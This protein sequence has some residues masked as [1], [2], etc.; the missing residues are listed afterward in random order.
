MNLMILNI[1][2]KAKYLTIFEHKFWIIHKY[3]QKYMQ[4]IHLHMHE[5]HLKIGAKK[6]ADFQIGSGGWQ[7][8]I[9]RR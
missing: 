6:L 7:A 5:L 1:L 4:N 9:K 8:Q 2:K 3:Y